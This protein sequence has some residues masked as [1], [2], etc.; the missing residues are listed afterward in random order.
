MCI[1]TGVNQEMCHIQ[2][3][4]QST[5]LQL[6]ASST[7]RSHLGFQLYHQDPHLVI[8]TGIQQLQRTAIPLTRRFGCGLRLSLRVWLNRVGFASLLI[9]HVLLVQPAI[10]LLVTPLATLLVAT[11]A[12]KLRRRLTLLAIVLL[13]AFLTIL[14][15]FLTLLDT[16]S[17]PILAA[18]VE[19]IDFHRS[20]AICWSWFSLSAVLLNFSNHIC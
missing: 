9:S 18:F 7:R 14:V 3:R 16:F 8:A 10:L 11:V 4:I 12:L 20:A 6:L 1:G 17:L 15:A 13:V 5:D 2:P 19:P